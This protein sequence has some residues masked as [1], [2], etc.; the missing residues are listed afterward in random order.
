MISNVELNELK[1]QCK[2]KKDVAKLITK[3]IN[4]DIL[5]TNNQLLDLIRFKESLSK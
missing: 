3:G 2:T 4:E 1:R 5:M